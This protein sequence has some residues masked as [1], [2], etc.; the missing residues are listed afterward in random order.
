MIGSGTSIAAV[1][2]TRSRKV[3]MPS[4]L[5][6]P[7]AVSLL[8]ERKRE[9]AQP[10]LDPIVEDEAKRQRLGDRLKGLD[11]TAMRIICAASPIAITPGRRPN[12]EPIAP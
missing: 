5:S 3:E 4:G 10:S 11:V 6:L 2:Q 9:L 7:L 12:S 8:P 1:M